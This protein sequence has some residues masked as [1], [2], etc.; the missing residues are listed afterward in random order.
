MPL[1]ADFFR[2]RYLRDFR[3]FGKDRGS[4]G[5]RRGVEGAGVWKRRRRRRRRSGSEAW[6]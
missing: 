6:G 1:G 5:A 2:Y 4:R 3:I